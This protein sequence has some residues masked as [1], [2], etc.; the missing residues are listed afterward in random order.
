MCPVDS[1]SLGFLVLECQC[2]LIAKATT[3]YSF[4]GGHPRAVAQEESRGSCE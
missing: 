2:W 1:E 3:S 4:Q